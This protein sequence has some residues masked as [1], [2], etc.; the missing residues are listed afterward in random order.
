MAKQNDIEELPPL[1]ITRLENLF[2]IY[3]DE[4][5]RFFYNLLR[6]VYFDE[7]SIPPEIYK[8]YTVMNGDTYT[9]IS[10]KVYGT[11]DLWWL[12]CS[13]NNI[14]NPTQ[15]PEPGTRLKILFTDYLSNILTAVKNK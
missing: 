15:I 8:Y 9:F 12:V 2:N 13:L 11:I 6:T 7:Q 4:K 1:K 5:N 14:N 10:Y 3:L